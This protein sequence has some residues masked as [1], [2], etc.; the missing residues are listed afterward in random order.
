ME[1]S[2]EMAFVS[3]VNVK[4]YWAY[5]HALNNRAFRIQGQRKSINM[6]YSNVSLLK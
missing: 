5:S 3:V 1:T 4:W 6:G 2:D